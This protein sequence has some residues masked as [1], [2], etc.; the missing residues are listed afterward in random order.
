MGSASTA[1][2]QRARPVRASSVYAIVHERDAD[3]T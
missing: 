3:A 1:A 2:S